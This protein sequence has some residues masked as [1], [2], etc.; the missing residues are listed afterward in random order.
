MY[1]VLFQFLNILVR[2][3]KNFRSHMTDIYLFISIKNWKLDKQ[4]NDEQGM[5]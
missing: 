4:I 5:M 2:I 3:D 1:I